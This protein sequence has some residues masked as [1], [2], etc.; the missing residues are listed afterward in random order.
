MRLWDSRVAL[1]L[2]VSQLFC[3]TCVVRVYLGSKPN[4]SGTSGEEQCRLLRNQEAYI[5]AV[6]GA[7]NQSILNLIHDSGIP[8]KNE[9]C[10]WLF[11]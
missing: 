8:Y 6:P 7:G 3:V 10:N 1:P 11:A 9:N 5:E 2:S 4:Y